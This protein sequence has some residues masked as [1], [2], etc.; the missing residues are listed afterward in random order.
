MAKKKRPDVNE[1]EAVVI[2]E[3]EQQDSARP[4]TGLADALRHALTNLGVEAETGE[5]RNHILHHFPDIDT[6]TPSFGSSLSGMRKKMRGGGN[7]GGGRGQRFAS[8][9]PN[10]STIEDL[11]TV[12][13]IAAERGGVEELLRQVQDITDLASEV[14]GFDRLRKA[15]EDLHDLT[16]D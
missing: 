8:S 9:R 5:I 13:R 2:T 16:A 4:R 12:K 7:E 1:E 10:V 6:S 15:L 14:G 3:P 11:K